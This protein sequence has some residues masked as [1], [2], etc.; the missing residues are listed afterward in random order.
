MLPNLCVNSCTNHRV[1]TSILSGDL[2]ARDYFVSEA[3]PSHIST[4]FL[5]SPLF[6]FKANVTAVKPE[7]P[8]TTYSSTVKSQMREKRAVR[9]NVSSTLTA[10]ARLSVSTCLGYFFRVPPCP[11]HPR[12][13][14]CFDLSRVF[15][16]GASTPPTS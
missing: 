7:A 4:C 6:D 1:L 8:Q 9:W 10:W 16:Q 12:K 11:L 2:C 15:L 3:I 13:F 5:F 14:F